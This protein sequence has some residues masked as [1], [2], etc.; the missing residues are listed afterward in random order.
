MNPFITLV[1]VVDTANDS[2]SPKHENRKIRINFNH[3]VSYRD[4]NITRKDGITTHS[5]VE[6]NGAGECSITYYTVESPE[7]I[8]YAI[9]LAI[10]NITSR[11]V[12]S[13][14]NTTP[15]S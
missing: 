12:D 4:F 2:Y 13:T 3:I 8:D 1:I 10:T 7:A 9:S 11:R 14:L 5:R 15:R 6:C